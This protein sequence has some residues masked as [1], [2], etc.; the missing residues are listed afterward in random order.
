LCA[1]CGQGAFSEVEITFLDWG[2]SVSVVVAW[3]CVAR[4]CSLAPH[5][6][7]E[8]GYTALYILLKQYI[9]FTCSPTTC[10]HAQAIKQNEI[11]QT[12]TITE[13]IVFSLPALAAHVILTTVAQAPGVSAGVVA[14]TLLPIYTKQALPLD[15]TSDDEHR[16]H[17][18]RPH[19]AAGK[20]TAHNAQPISRCHTYTIAAAGASPNMVK[21]ATMLRK[22]IVL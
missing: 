7:I 18:R 21:I 20:P 22:W 17:S 16:S 10:A 5:Q 14:S 6:S 13:S 9:H 2:L 1:G 12:N 19:P 3:R 8:T 4:V 15:A 11:R